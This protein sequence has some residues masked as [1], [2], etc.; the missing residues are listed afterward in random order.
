MEHTASP[1]CTLAST[2]EIQWR[3]QWHPTPALLP[4]KSHGWRSLVGCSPWGREESDMTEA[5]QQQQQQQYP[6]TLMF[7]IGY[8]SKKRGFVKEFSKFL[9]LYLKY[10]KL[11]LNQS[12]ALKVVSMGGGRPLTSEGHSTSSGWGSITATSPTPTILNPV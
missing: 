7:K 4:G 9:S 11:D 6:E 5:M 3:R 8:Y 2:R 12:T 1:G 10:Q